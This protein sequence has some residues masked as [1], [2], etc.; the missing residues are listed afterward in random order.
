MRLHAAQKALRLWPVMLVGSLLLTALLV[1]AVDATRSSAVRAAQPSVA[2]KGAPFKGAVAK[3]VVNLSTLPKAANTGTSSQ[4]TL[5]L[6]QRGMSPQQQAEYDKNAI[7]LPSMPSAVAHPMP[8]R[9]AATSPS[10][11]G[12]GVLPHVYKS[13]E[14]LNSAQGTGNNTG[15]NTMATD[16]S[17]VMQASANAIGIFSSASGALLYGPYTSSSFFAPVKI[18]GDFLLEPQTF[19]DVMRD[20]WIVVYSELTIPGSSVDHGYIDI[21]VSQTNSPTQPAPG[22]Q[23]W[24]Y[25]LEATQFNTQY[26]EYCSEPQIG[27]DYWGLYIVCQAISGGPGQ[28]VG[29]YVLALDKTR[30]YNGTSASGSVYTNIPVDLST[31]GAGGN[32]PCPARKLSPA[33]EDGVPDAEF[34]TSI[35]EN[36]VTVSSNLTLCA[37]TNTNALTGIATSPILTCGNNMLP[38]PYAY[39]VSAQLPGGVTWNFDN[40]PSRIEYKAGMLH[41][42]WTTAATV[43]GS[44][45]DGIYWLDIQPLLTTVAEHS[46]QWVNG[47]VVRNQGIWALSSQT[48]LFSPILWTTDEQD[49]ALIYQVVSSAHNIYPSIGYTGRKATDAVNTLGQDTSAF[50]V[51]GTRASSDGPPMCALPLNS[52][53]RGIVWCSA[54]YGASQPNPGW[55]TRIFALRTE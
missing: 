54:G 16:L 42:S 37:M 49:D 45:V 24:L 46:P 27:A 21:A 38:T 33:V 43:S 19:Y 28:Y 41:L 25:R 47:M 2:I 4:P 13:F 32:S 48:Y 8:D 11:V 35:D 10:F 9:S 39:P 34:F 18:N 7:H 51:T 23:Y 1:P 6:P 31:C 15:G 17:Y 26:G 55:D 44:S 3:G 50:V 5:P 29:N 40:S 52:V 36:Y 20:R 53:T 22:G 30:L 12:G 14:G